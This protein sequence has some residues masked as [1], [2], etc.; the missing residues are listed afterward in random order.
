MT[1]KIDL[2]PKLLLK[3]PSSHHSGEELSAFIET[4]TALF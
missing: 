3:K 1:F 4:I 2:S